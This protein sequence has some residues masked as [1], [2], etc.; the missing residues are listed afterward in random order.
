MGSSDIA[1]CTCA[2]GSF[3][4]ECAPC[5]TGHP[6]PHTRLT[7][8]V[9]YIDNPLVRIHFITEMIYPN[10]LAPWEFVPFPGSSL[11]CLPSS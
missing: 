10:G 2:A 8:R 7:E 5:P 3:G 6:Q 4:A 11:V 1:S 9:F